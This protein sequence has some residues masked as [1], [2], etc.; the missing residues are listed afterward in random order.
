[1]F[2]WTYKVDLAFV[3]FVGFFI[4]ACLTSLIIICLILFVM[5]RIL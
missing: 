1:M 5:K 4:E 2:L 3:I